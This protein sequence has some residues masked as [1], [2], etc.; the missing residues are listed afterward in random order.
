MQHPTRRFSS[1]V[2]NYVKYRPH[3][4]SCVLD[5]LCHECG[6][7]PNWRVADIGSGT[8]FLTELFLQNGNQ[9]FA[10][11]PNKEMRKAAEALLKNCPGFISIDGTA[12]DTTLPEAAVDMVAA[13]QAFHWFDRDKAKVEFARILGPGGWVILVWNERRM[14]SSFAH[15]YEGL[16]RE[17]SP[18]YEKADHRNIDRKTL[19]DFFA[20][21]DFSLHTCENAQAFD[22]MGLQ[23]RLLSSSYAPEADNEA[24][25]SELARIFEQYQSDGR[26]I[27]HYHTRVYF[28][29]WL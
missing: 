9:T 2:E 7:T 24:M 22:A 1:R 20:P 29:Q 6:L 4:P 18:E 17:Y 12:E 15:A 10:V 28:S 3:Y 19:K 14:D 11:E 13:G 8:G 26:V 21:A 27:F 25:L 23:G 5:I 16:L